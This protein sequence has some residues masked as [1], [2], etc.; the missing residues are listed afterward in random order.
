MLDGKPLRFAM[1]QGA[2]VV[3]AAAFY[4]DLAPRYDALFA[5]WWEGA[6]WHGTVVSRLLEW[7]GVRAPAAVLDCACGIGTQALLLAQS[8]YQVTGT[9]ISEGAIARG[10][11][12]AA[13]RHI[14]VEL[15]VADFRRLREVVTGPFDAV[16]A[17]D[18]ALPH[19]LTDE[20]LTSAVSQIWACL[21]PGGTFM[22]SIRDYDELAELRPVGVPIALH[23]EVGRR[24]GAGQSWV[25][26]GDGDFVDI[27]LFTLFEGPD[28]WRT[29]G[30]ETRYRAL[31]R[32]RLTQVL[33]DEGFTAV[34]WLGVNESGYFQPVVIAT[35][36]GVAG[37]SDS[38][39]AY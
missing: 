35:A 37:S 21:R 36:L 23:G 38:G 22:A 18:N 39:V 29:E 27:T 3:D 7:E 14:P 30:T 10:R 9:D 24:H 34:R 1:W 4:D 12:E 17:C 8:G 19:L 16:I 2:S 11:S 28:G 15:H 31:R 33:C 5:D 32:E 13:S 26:T 25:W 6:A 20:D